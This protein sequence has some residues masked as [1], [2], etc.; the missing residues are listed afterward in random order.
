MYVVAVAR[1]DVLVRETG[2]PFVPYAKLGVGYALWWIK[3]GEQTA[4]APSDGREGRG[5]SYGP[6]FALGA[7]LQLDWIDRD[8]VRSADTS[9]GMNHSYIFAEWYRSM[10][11]GFGSDDQLD[12]GTDTWMLGLAL[13]F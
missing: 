13:E 1:A 12:A 7:M 10:L 6:Q 2:V 9:I 4:V 5:A 8:D 3:S 11:D